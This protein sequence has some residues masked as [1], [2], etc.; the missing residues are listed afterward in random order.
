MKR[1]ISIVLLSG[2][3]ALASV[4]LVAWSD[5]EGANV[6]EPASL[7]PAGTKQAKWIG[8][9][10]GEV[11][12]IVRDHIDVAE[13]VGL[14]VIRVVE[15]SPAAKAGLHQNDILLSVNGSPLTSPGALVDAVGDSEDS[16]IKLEYL[17]RGKRETVELAAVPRPEL[18]ASA[19]PDLPGLEDG[20]SPLGDM[21]DSTDE[22]M[23]Q[24]IERLQGRQ[25]GSGPRPNLRLRRIM[26]PGGGRGSSSAQAWSLPNGLSVQIQKENDKPAKIKV[27][28]GDK[29]WDLT[30][31][32]IDQLPE[33]IR[34]HVQRMLGKGA[35]QFQW[36]IRPRDLQDLDL[37]AVP[38]FGDM[39]RELDRMNRRMDRLFD[40]LRGLKGFEHEHEGDVEEEKEDLELRGREA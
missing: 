9:A 21:D 6:S 12:D 32:D 15:E 39:E 35:S 40:E 1:L 14:M 16:K 25:S 38:H 27:Q 18:P 11:P 10:V 3:A 22:L 31:N 5:E 17:R 24:L 2:L 4:P 34:P 28:S 26:P 13:G 19:L 23:R 37:E 20:P 8:V 30:E 36:N 7:G 29:T 33:D